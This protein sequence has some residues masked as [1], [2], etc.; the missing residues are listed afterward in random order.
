MKRFFEN[1]K[2]FWVRY[3]DYVIRED[4]N[5]VKYLQAGD[6]AVPE[7]YDPTDILENLVVDALNVGWTCMDSDLAEEEKEDAVCGFVL[8]YGMLGFMTALPTTP[9]FLSYENV[10]FD[11]NHFIKKESMTVEDYLAIFFPFE[12]LKLRKKNEE[13]TL[14]IEG[15]KHMVA[16][17]TMTDGRPLEVHM[18]FQR[19]YTERMDWLKQQFKDWAFTMMTIFFYYE[20]LDHVAEDAKEYYRQSMA[21]FD[22]ITPTYHIELQDDGPMLVWNLNS[23]L[24]GVQ[25]MICSMLTDS[26]N[27]VKM[28]RNCGRAFIAKRYRDKFCSKECSDKYRQ[29]E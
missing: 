15:D 18:S 2:S 11:K 4:G 23:L 16:L 8:K 26:R 27:P 29:K 5:G 1:S 25:L 13:Y 10:Y 28:C 3:N 7:P 6:G 20:E 19:E 17:A 14:E 24:Q 21:A 9:R 22:G 12:K